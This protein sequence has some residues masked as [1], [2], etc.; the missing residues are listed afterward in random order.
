[1]LITS[2]LIPL[3]LGFVLIALVAGNNLSVCFG[4]VISSR[5]LSRKSGII[6]TM[7]GYTAGLLLQGNLLSATVTRL[8]PIPTEF[9][10][11]AAL[12]I[13]I[14]IFVVS[15]LKRIPQSLSITFTMTLV[16]MA[17][18]SGI[19]LN[20]VFLSGVAIV[21]LLIPILS[22]LAV[23]LTLKLVGTRERSNH[24][25]AYTRLLKAILIVASFFVAFTL[26]ANTIGL[27][28]DFLPSTYYTIYISIAA[29]V[30]GS[31]I[32]SAGPLRRVGSDIIPIRYINAVSSQVVSAILVEI[33][34]VF[35]IPMSNTQ[36]FV[37]SVY[38]AGASYK[39]RLILKSP[40][41]LM[42]E[43]WLI[44]AFIAFVLG[45]VVIKIA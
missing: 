35:G 24:I 1:M 11:E 41:I 43:T 8:M 32:F 42:V 28:Q 19:S 13:A 5:I 22:F 4:S 23:L 3:I 6:L 16:G 12:A 20:W 26:G 38:G 10:I 2:V 45:F 25:W 17:I 39:S 36:T 14:V 9:T 21:W 31:I 37:S 30:A 44:T 40:F 34:T 29:I 18:A 15:Q 27:I 7:A 33:A